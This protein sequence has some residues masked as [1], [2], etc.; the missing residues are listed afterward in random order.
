MTTLLLFLH[1]FNRSTSKKQSLS[2]WQLLYQKVLAQLAKQGMTKPVAM[3]VNDFAK[4][5]REQYPELAIVFTRLSASYN[6]LCYQVLS[7]DEQLTLT[8]AMQQQ[9]RHFLQ[10]L[11]KQP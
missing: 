2:S 9:Y 6:C 7:T 11:K 5:V 1:F 8:L 3:T 10:T 4:Q